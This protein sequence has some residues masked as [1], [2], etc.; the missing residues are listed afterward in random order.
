[1]S[2]NQGGTKTDRRLYERR[3]RTLQ[4]LAIYNSIKTAVT[5]VAQEFHCSEW[6]VYKDISRMEKWVGSLR[7]DRAIAE[8]LQSRMEFYSGEA[9]MLVLN[10]KPGDQLSVRDKFVKIAALNVALRIT[11]EQKKF[12]Q[13]LGWIQCK[14]IEFKISNDHMPFEAVPEVAAV[15]QKMFEQQKA[16]K[17]AAA[18]AALEAGR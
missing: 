3:L 5:I 8:K 1:M 17:D 2:K 18:K 9:N 14:P 13:E 6:A 16:E 15:Y 11:V 10:D 4:L 7:Q 12:A